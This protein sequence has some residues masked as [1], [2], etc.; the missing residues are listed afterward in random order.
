MKE[1]VFIHGRSQQNQVASAL[2]HESQGLSKS[3][4]ELPIPES[5]IHFPYYGDTLANLVDGLPPDK[6]ADVI[7]RGDNIGNAEKLFQLSILR[8]IQKQ[9]GLTDESLLHLNGRPR[10]YRFASGPLPP[11][12]ATMSGAANAGSRVRL[13]EGDTV[14]YH[15][16]AGGVG[17]IFTQWARSLG[18][19]VIG[20]V[21]TAEKAQI[22]LQAG[23]KAAVNYSTEDFVERTFELTGGLAVKAVYDSVGK[24]T[25]RGSLSVLRPRGTLVQFGNASGFPEPINP[26]E[27]APRALYLT[28]AILPHYN[29]TP[30]AL[31]A[32][33]ADL[34][35]TIKSGI[36]KV[37]PTNIYRFDQLIHAHQQLEQRRTV[38]AT[39]LHV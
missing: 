29:N 17:Q 18:I 3:N 31:A 33:S 6:V 39:V 35:H 7:V 11:R 1:P 9:S 27:P 20:T 34:F 24:D 25:F 14:L 13:H 26:F 36:L 21:S 30:E 4:L 8:E 19:D 10:T 12:S 37:D 32:S 16:A 22:A 15:A 23:C 28:W 2:K 5:S 38:G